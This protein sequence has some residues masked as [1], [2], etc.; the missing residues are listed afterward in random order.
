MKAIVNTVPNRLEMRDLPTPAPQAGQVRVKVLACGICAT[1]LE[2]IKGWRRTGFP[3]IP[4]H[5]WSGRID[6]VGSGVDAGLVG[7]KCVAENVLSDGGE[8]GFE[9]PG[10]YGEFLLTEAANVRVLSDDSC[11][12]VTSLIEPL[13]VCVRAMKRLGGH[14]QASGGDAI[15]IFGDG[16]IGLLLAAMLKQDGSAFV[17]LAGGRNV[18]LALARQ[19]GA[20][21]TV[22]YHDAGERLAE[23]MKSAASPARGFSRVIEASGSAAGMAAAMQCAAHDA[24]ILVIGDYGDGRASFP[25]NDLLHR[26]LTLVGSNAS[27]G[28]WD[29]AVRI[30]QRGRLGLDKLISH[31]LP[32]ERFAEGIELARSRDAVKVV[33]E[34]SE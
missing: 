10:G 31:H 11:A 5:E 25:W 6:A 20:D 2:M 19:L 1:D 17:A 28:A 26:E 16:P 15:A 7:R 14:G 8:V 34:W 9:H 22:N 27:A 33:M 4:G 12:R 13:A 29:E 30:A 21:A 18:R 3:A 24:R 32:A 23:T